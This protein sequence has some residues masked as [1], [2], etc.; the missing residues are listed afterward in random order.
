V[1]LFD[2]E[3]AAFV[4]VRRSDLG[5]E[6]WAE[7]TKLSAGGK[8]RRLCWFG[9]PAGRATKRCQTGTGPSGRSG[10]TE[11]SGEPCA[12]NRS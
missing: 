3:Q 11:G 1:S 4:A 9:M 8:V 6:A 5:A 12:A 7:A 10:T 2:S